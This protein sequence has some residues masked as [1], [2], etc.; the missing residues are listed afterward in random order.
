MKTINNIIKIMDK[1]GI[2]QLSGDLQEIAQLRI[3]HPDYSIQ[4]LAESLSQP[5][6][7]SGVNHR[8]RKLNKIAEEL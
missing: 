4:Q 7:K 1:I 2:D 8:L 6:T 3:Q 5:I